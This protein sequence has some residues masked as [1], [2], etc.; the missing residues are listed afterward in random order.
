MQEGREGGRERW[1]KNKRERER[2]RIKR[3]KIAEEDSKCYHK[4]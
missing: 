2:E 3:S 4:C 1:R